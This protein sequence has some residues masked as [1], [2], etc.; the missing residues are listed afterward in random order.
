M[1]EKTQIPVTEDSSETDRL[2]QMIA[3]GDR[4]ALGSL[5]AQHRDYLRRVVIALH[6]QTLKLRREVLG[7]WHSHTLLS[8]IDRAA[9]YHAGGRYP[10]AEK[11]YDQ[12]IDFLQ[13]PPADTGQDPDTIDQIYAIVLA[14]AA[15]SKLQLKQPEKAESLARESLKLRVRLIPEH[16]ARFSA[17]SLLGEALLQ[18]GKV[19]AA[20]QHLLGGF[21]GMQA[22]KETM[23]ASAHR[24][25]LE[26]C[27]SL[28]DLYQAKANAEQAEHWKQTLASLP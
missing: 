25:L 21:A 10:E 6:E 2:L 8:I 28:V 12:A 13:N 4:E 7:P 1:G 24:R 11:L 16:W 27:Q 14:G 22:R 20:E 9:A 18:Q 15:E 26:S 23:P 17:Q 5:I 3:A 19:D